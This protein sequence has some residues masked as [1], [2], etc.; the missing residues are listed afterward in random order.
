MT[1]VLPDHEVLTQPIAHR[2]YTTTLYD[3]NATAFIRPDEAP[4]IL[5][6]P[7]DAWIITGDI[8]TGDPA[9]AAEWTRLDDMLTEPPTGNPPPLP[10]PPPTPAKGGRPRFY[11]GERR[12]PAPRWAGYAIVVGA[13][14]PFWALITIA[15]LAAFR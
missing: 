3:I 5:G 1:D 15:V 8:R 2:R 14:A 6:S 9:H 13:S 10:P 11:H 4:I 7:T 12:R